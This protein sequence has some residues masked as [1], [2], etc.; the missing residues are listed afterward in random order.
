[1]QNGT[2]QTADRSGARDTRVRG[3]LRS[4]LVVLDGTLDG[5]AAVDVGVDLGAAHGARVTAAAPVA[6]AGGGSERPYGLG[7]QMFERMQPP[8]PPRNLERSDPRVLLDGFVERCRSHRVEHR[9]VD[10]GSVPPGRILVESQ[11]HDLVVMGRDFDAQAAWPRE[12]G[13]TLVG[14]MQRSPRP[15]VVVPRE[16]A[17]SRQVLVAYDGGPS[18]ARAL[19]A[20]LGLGL[21]EGGQGVHVLTVAD[22]GSTEEALARADPG[23]DFLRGHDVLATRSTSNGDRSVAAT[24]L[25]EAGRRDASLILMGTHAGSRLKEALLGSVTTQ[26]LSE[27][28]RPV[29]CHC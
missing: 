28:D 1:M 25:E 6:A 13:S 19:Q 21:L 17:G 24:V 3:R 5:S 23:V 8:E 9:L 2:R 27:T 10:E 4:L 14:F 26:V 11:R 16:P 20:A 15:V 7:A 22:G 18:A 12:A 29:L